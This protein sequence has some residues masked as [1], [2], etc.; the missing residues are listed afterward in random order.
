[1]F[2]SLHESVS[3]LN[4]LVSLA[5]TAELIEMLFGMWTLLSPRYLVL[6]TSLEPSQ[7]LI[8]MS[9]R[10]SFLVWGPVWALGRCDI[11]PPRFLAECC[12]R[13][14]NQGSF[15]LLYFRLFTFSDLFEFVYLYFPVLFCLSV[16]VK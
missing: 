1:M 15:V 4:T 9:L 8:G 7:A 14:L 12:K 16:S 2:V 13:Q 10:W 6:S 5:K 3:A 11:R